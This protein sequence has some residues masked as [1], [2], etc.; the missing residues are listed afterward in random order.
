MYP[1]R[2]HI[3]HTYLDEVYGGERDIITMMMGVFLS[4]SVPSWQ[5]V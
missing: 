3:D 4:D 5:S 1:F 2:R